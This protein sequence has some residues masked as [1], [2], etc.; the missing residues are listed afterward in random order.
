MAETKALSR[1]DVLNARKPEKWLDVPE[2]G[3]RVLLRPLSLDKFLAVMDKAGEANGEFGKRLVAEMLI[4]P[5]TDAPMF[6]ADEIQLIGELHDAPVLRIINAAKQM[7]GLTADV[8]KAP[9][10]GSSAT[11]STATASN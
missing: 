10:S 5:E 1:A 9:A 11:D 8:P 3:G 6:S 7:L 2:L 4:D